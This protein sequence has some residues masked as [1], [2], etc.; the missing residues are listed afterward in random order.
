M[1]KLLVLFCACCTV[2][3]L[4]AAVPELEALVPAA[5]GYEKIA[6]FNPLEWHRNGYVQNDAAKFKSAPVRVGYL[7]I[8]TG[9]SGEKQ[10][11]FAAMNGFAGAAAAA[12]YLVPAQDGKSWQ[13]FVEDLEVASN[14]AGVATGRFARG[15]VEI[16]NNDYFGNNS[17]KIPGAADNR[18]DFGDTRSPGG[19]YGSFQ[20]H[21]FEKLQ[22]VLSFSN[23]KAGAHCDLGIG[24]NPQEGGQP[25]WTFSGAGRNWQTAQLFIVGQFAK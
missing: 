5:T 12:D 1:K 11:V 25:D 18:I 6:V 16:W 8:L 9:A 2:G 21:N 13:C 4:F 22:T 23:F 19:S 10:W 7:L 3:R 17:L 20:I 15:N 24:N 14:V